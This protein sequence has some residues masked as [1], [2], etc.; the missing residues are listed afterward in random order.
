MILVVVQTLLHKQD[1]DKPFFFLCRQFPAII[2]IYVAMQMMFSAIGNQ[3][4]MFHVLQIL[5]EIGFVPFKKVHEFRIL[6]G[7]HFYR[8]T[9]S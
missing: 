2:G 9:T 3:D 1:F 5:I 6:Y 7:C 8:Y 4:I